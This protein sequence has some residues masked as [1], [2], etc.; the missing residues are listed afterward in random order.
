[1]QD[2]NLNGIPLSEIEEGSNP[3]EKTSRLVRRE[4]FAE[5]LGCSQTTLW[6]L[7]KKGVVPEPIRISER[8][9]VWHEL[10]VQEFIEG[11]RRS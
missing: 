4:E 9:V 7:I 11:Y 5:R 8:I 1:M 6:R 2:S 10:D 3:V